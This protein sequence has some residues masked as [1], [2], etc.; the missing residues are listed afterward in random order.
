MTDRM[1]AILQ[2]LWRDRSAATAIE[3]ALIAVFIALLIVAGATAI[4]TSV[5]LVFTQAASGI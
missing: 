4:G 5:S 3:Y 2:A 1:R